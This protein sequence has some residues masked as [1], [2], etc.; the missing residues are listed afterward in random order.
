MND[1]SKSKSRHCR[2]IAPYFHWKATLPYLFCF[3]KQACEDGKAFGFFPWSNASGVCVCISA[4]VRS[5]SLCGIVRQAIGPFHKMSCI[6][7]D[8][9]LQQIPFLVFFLRPDKLNLAVIRLISPFSCRYCLPGSV[10]K[11]P[12][13]CLQLSETKSFSSPVISSLR[14]CTRRDTACA[15]SRVKPVMWGCKFRCGVQSIWTSARLL[16]K[17]DLFFSPVQHEFPVCK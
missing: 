8:S 7:G 10:A 9:C 1:I 6:H 17:W 14:P 5:T 3:F 2:N 15:R 12:Y 13:L 4:C 11:Q 16:N